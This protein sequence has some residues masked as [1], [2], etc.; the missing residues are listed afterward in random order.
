MVTAL[1][2]AH[3]LSVGT[4][5]SPHLERVN[6]RISRNGEPITD[7]AARRA[8]SPSWPGLE[9]LPG[10]EPSYFELLTAAA[11][12]WFAEIAVDV[13]VV[14]VGLLGRCDAT[15]VVDA[16]VA[17]RHQRRPRPH[18]RR[19]R[20]ARR[21]I[22]AEKAGI[23]KPGSFLVLGETDPQLAVGVPRRGPA[24][25]PWARGDDFDVDRQPAGGRRPRARP[26]HARAARSTTCSSRCTAA[27]R[28]TTRRCAVAAVEAFFGRA[29]DRRGRARPLSPASPCPGGSRS[30]ATARWCILDGAHNPDGAAGRGRDARR[31][32][33]R[34][35]GAASLVVGMLGGPRPG[36]DAR[37]AR[38]APRRPRRRLHA[39]LSPG[40]CRP[41]SSPPSP[42]APG[43]ARPSRSTTS[44]DRRRPGR[45]AVADRGRRR[46]RH[47]LALR[48]RRRPRRTP[49]RCL[50]AL[51][52]QGRARTDFVAA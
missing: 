17:V 44:A 33:R 29:L 5:T 18:R 9:P 48:R 46:A 10:V 3:G 27:T 32:V 15:N 16:E 25:R 38:R 51:T 14:E 39:R 36:A 35:P 34:R 24:R 22:A 7:D 40:R 6:E 45:C 42:R 20:L 47:R 41:P 30:W 26:P 49:G 19:G 50:T 12:P 8:S 28:P 52:D 37:G 23:V 4:Y 1:L 2:V 21:R 13:A 31:G 11:L 43:R